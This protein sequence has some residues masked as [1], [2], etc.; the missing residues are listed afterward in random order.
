[1]AGRGAVG[2]P[3]TLCE[4]WLDASGRLLQREAHCA[5]LCPAF[6][7]CEL[8]WGS[9]LNPGLVPSPPASPSP[10]NGSPEQP[11]AHVYPSPP[12][13]PICPK[14]PGVQPAAFL[15]GAALERS[16]RR[17]R[18][19]RPDLQPV[20]QPL[21]GAEGWLRAVWQ[22]CGLRAAADGTGGAHRY[23]GQP[24][25]PRQLHHPRG[26][27]QWRLGWQPPGRTALR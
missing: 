5:V 13:P 19:Q 21:P 8:P 25:A 20:V 26:G 14:G 6:P 16:C 18:P 2:A 15:V 4:L 7:S 10:T 11:Q 24:A 27:P 12:R 3:H 17:G 9:C 22:W 1:M 23:A